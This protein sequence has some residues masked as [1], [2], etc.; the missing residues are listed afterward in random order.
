MFLNINKRNNTTK[1]GLKVGSYEATVISIGYHP[2]YADE[3]ALQVTYELVNG[4]GERFTYKETFINNYRN[5]RTKAFFEYLESNGIPVDS[6]EN[7]CG[8]KENIVLKKNATN[9]GTFLNIDEREFVPAA[10]ESE[11]DQNDGLACE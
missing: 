3:G 8:C 1:S 7:F 11:V 10:A 6:L 4:S 5:A 2:D 9:R